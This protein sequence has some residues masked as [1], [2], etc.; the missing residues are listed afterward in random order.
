M[1]KFLF[2]LVISI[3]S[4]CFSQTKVELKKQFLKIGEQ[5]ELIYQ[6]RY[7]EKQGQLSF[8]PHQN[9][10]PCI[11]V[12]NSSLNAEKTID[13]E[14]LKPFKD[15]I[16]K[17]KNSLIWTGTYTVTAWDTGN[18]V[19]PTT[20][21]STQ[22]SVY[23]FSEVKFEVISPKLEEGKEIFDIKEQFIEVPETYFSWFTTNWYWFLL[24]LIFILAFL[25]FK[26]K[27][28]K[29]QIP[30]KIMSLKEKSLLVLD[31]LE[32]AKM[33]EKEQTKEHYI[34]LSFILRSYL[35]AQYTL[36]L[37]EKTSFEAS[38]LL[39]KKP[40]EKDTIQ[41][42]KTLLDYSD[43]VKFAKSHPNE[44]EILKNIA[45]VRQIIVE[46]SPIEINHV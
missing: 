45:Q 3:S 34:E 15:S 16:F 43:L 31:A 13:L 38:L 5:T 9:S 2:I 37:L 27:N 22:D 42:I 7:E 41:V 6:I 14:I 1:R 4:F 46:T 44:Y 29:G 32:K 25:Y 24:L 18:F 26:R 23:S 11:V 20:S 30:E 17:E 19:I 21:I 35:S 33:W 39:E 36:N 28:K 40:L 10:I 8:I 12:K